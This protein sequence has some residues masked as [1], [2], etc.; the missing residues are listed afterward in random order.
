MYMSLLCEPGTIA[1][2]A[3]HLESAVYVLDATDF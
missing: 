3:K 2:Q 1:W